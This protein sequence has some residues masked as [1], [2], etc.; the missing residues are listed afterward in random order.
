MNDGKG[1]DCDLNGNQFINRAIEDLPP[2]NLGKQPVL[3]L[4]LGAH[5]L[6]KSVFYGC[7]DDPSLNLDF[8]AWVAF[9]HGCEEFYCDGHTVI[10]FLHHVKA[11][12]YTILPQRIG[13]NARNL[14]HFGL[15]CAHFY[16]RVCL[17]E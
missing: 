6:R 7:L 10:L 17:V 3:L 4:T 8:H 15:E 14:R 2:L 13:S 11:D 1:V 16:W 9:L 5:T 12:D